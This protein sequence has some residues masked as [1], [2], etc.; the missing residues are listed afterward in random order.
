MVEI[1]KDQFYNVNLV[2][3]NSKDRNSKDAYI[4][5]YDDGTTIYIYAEPCFRANSNISNQYKDIKDKNTTNRVD[6]NNNN[7]WLEIDFKKKYNMPIFNDKKI[8]FN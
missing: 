4:Y 1:D 6:I 3:S 8:Y 5:Y 7:H 2:T